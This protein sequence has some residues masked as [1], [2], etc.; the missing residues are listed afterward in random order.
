MEGR[1]KGRRREEEGRKQGAQVGAL[2][3]AGVLL[4]PVAAVFLVRACFADH[5]APEE[6]RESKV[7]VV[8][9]VCDFHPQDP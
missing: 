4:A 9:F 6:R 3:R 7:V 1:E 2:R 5:R 8:L